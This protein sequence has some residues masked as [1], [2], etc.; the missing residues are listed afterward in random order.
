MTTEGECITIKSESFVSLYHHKE[1]GFVRIK[2]KGNITDQQYK[3]FWNELLDYGVANG[4][5]KIL[6]DQ[7]NIGHV[8]MQARAWL[9]IKWL[10]RVKKSYNN[11]TAAI[12]SSGSLLH[13]SGMQYLVDSIK[14]ATNFD[15]RFFQQQEDAVLWLKTKP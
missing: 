7:R 1:D 10:P 2:W 5:Q 12:L 6:I 14:N 8:S 4:I 13:K 11:F 3:A 9:L 15:L